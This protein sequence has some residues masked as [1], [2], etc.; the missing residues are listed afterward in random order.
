MLSQSLQGSTIEQRSNVIKELYESVN[1]AESIAKENK[2][3][4]VAVRTCDTA[5][6]NASKILDPLDPHIVEAKEKL[7]LILAMVHSATPNRAI[8]E[9]GELLAIRKQINGPDSRKMAIT[10]LALCRVLWDAGGRR[11][12]ASN[13]FLMVVKTHLDILNLDADLK[14]ASDIGIDLYEH[15]KKF[16]AENIFRAILERLK[17]TN[18]LHGLR[19]LEARRWL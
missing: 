17:G 1:L 2:R 13:H 14:L 11:D 15:G 18:K 5:I 19:T 10:R 6:Q 8:N 12:E 3:P 16:E 4:G 7:A 9:Y